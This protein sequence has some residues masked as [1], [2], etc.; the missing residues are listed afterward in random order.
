MKRIGAILCL[1]LMTVFMSASVCFA[2]QGDLVIK[3][4]YPKDGATGTAVENASIKIWFNQDVKPKT[5]DIRKANKKAIKLVDEKGKSVPIYVAYSPDEEGLMMVL[6]SENAQ[7]KGD[8]KYTLTIDSSFQATSGDTLAKGDKVAFKTLNQS[9]ATT[10]NMVMMAVMMVGMIFFSSRSMKKQMEKE[11]NEKGKQE[12]VNPYKEAKRT[13][14]SVEE[15]VEKDKKNKEKQAAAA[16]K[17][18]AK[19]EKERQ[20][21]EA[22]ALEE[23]KSSNK[24]VAGPRPISAAGGKYKAPKKTQKKAQQNKGTTRPKNQTGK[25]KNSKNKK[26]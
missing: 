8:T 10:V 23:A 13:G 6:S 7:I 16:A 25:Q 1:A 9:Q 15:I 12:T 4:Q 24:R 11:K 26:K 22:A 19:R 14:K 5:Q 2:G 20:E 18:A 17:R 21:E 3:D